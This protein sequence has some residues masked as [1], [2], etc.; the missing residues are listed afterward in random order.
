MGLF[1][2]FKSSKSDKA[3]TEDVPSQPDI[4]RDKFVDDHQ[5][6][7]SVRTIRYGTQLPIDI[8]YSYIND[9]Y[10][11]QG[12]EDALCNSDNSYKKSKQEIIRNQLKQL[13]VQVNL[14]YNSDIRILKVQI[15]SIESQGLLD[16]AREL[17]AR[18]E[19]YE[20]HVS[21]L[22]LMEKGLDDNDPKMT[23]MIQSYDRGFLKGLVAKSDDLLHYGN[24]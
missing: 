3:T 17:G 12:Y 2:F 24:E 6:D 7:Q 20:E 16:K 5:S 9:D 18:L 13:F 14:R 19:T 15:D 8:I 22:A 11:T 23:S 4:P 1:S 21:Q 10:E